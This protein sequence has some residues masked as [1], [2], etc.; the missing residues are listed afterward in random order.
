MIGH[1]DIENVRSIMVKSKKFTCT[2]EEDKKKWDN[3]IEGFDDA[4]NRFFIKEVTQNAR[5]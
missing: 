2:T 3:L 1:K 5:V 4:A